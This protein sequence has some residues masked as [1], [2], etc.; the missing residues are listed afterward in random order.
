ML[1]FK[2]HLLFAPR[3]A[4]TLIR[5]LGRE[6]APAIGAVAVVQPS[7]AHIASLTGSPP[8]ARSGSL[9]SARL[10]WVVSYSFPSA[11]GSD[12]GRLSELSRRAS[13]G[14]ARGRALLWRRDCSGPAE[15]VPVFCV[16]VSGPRHIAAFGHSTVLLLQG[17]KG[18][19][20]GGPLAVPARLP[21]ALDVL[22]PEVEDHHRLR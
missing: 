6:V 3:A 8:C 18:G 13:D 5:L 4:I 2:M 16:T 17:A 19:I 12:Q 15:K 10:P 14:A 22:V 21:L 9:Q 11:A 1:A 7:L 20:P